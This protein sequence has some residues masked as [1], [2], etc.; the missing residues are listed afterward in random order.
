MNIKHIHIHEYKVFK[1]FDINFDFEDISQ[2]LIVL[3]GENGNGKTILL[4][5]ILSNTITTNKPQC[6]ITMQEE[7]NEPDTFIFPMPYNNEK[8]TTIF[9]K[10]HYHAMDDNS[11]IYKFQEDVLSCIN[12]STHQKELTN[13]ETYRKIQHLINNVFQEFDLQLRFKELSQDN[14]LIFT[15]TKEAELDIEDLSRGEKQILSIIFALFIK[16]T[17]EKV[18]LIDDI[19]NSLQPSHQLQILSLLRNCSKLNNSQII[20]S[21]QSPLVISSAHKEEIRLLV[22]DNKGFVKTKI[23]DNS[24][25]G[26]TINKVLSEIQKIK[27]LRVPEVENR[28]TELKSLMWENKQESQEFKQKLV[29]MENILGFSDPDLILIRMEISC[30][31]KKCIE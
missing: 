14:K 21:T 7:E 13:N 12:K 24:P 15:N 23:C 4:K 1:D 27:Y 22:R 19:E 25:Y 9:S 29:E 11:N 5:D 30:K 10:I 18:I 3:T 8:Y 28:L 2:N 16:D 20:V 31:K 6:I 17:K 26:W